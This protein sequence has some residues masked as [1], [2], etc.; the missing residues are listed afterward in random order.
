MSDYTGSLAEEAY[1]DEINRSWETCDEFAYTLCR[2]GL[3]DKTP[4]SDW[5]S[6]LCI[7]LKEGKE[8]LEKYKLA[9]SWENNANWE[10]S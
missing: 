7:F 1:L 6:Q 10:P 5:A 8:A 9:T 3:L 4:R 2:F